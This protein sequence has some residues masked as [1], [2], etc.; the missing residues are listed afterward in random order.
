MDSENWID[1][2]VIHSWLNMARSQVCPDTLSKPLAQALTEAPLL[3]SHALASAL[4]VGSSYEGR[5]MGFNSL[6]TPLGMM[7]NMFDTCL[8]KGIRPCEISGSVEMINGL[9]AYLNALD[10][11]PSWTVFRTASGYIGRGPPLVKKG[12]KVC[13]F[14]GARTPFIIRKAAMPRF[15]P[16]T[17]YH[18]VGECYVEGLMSKEATRISRWKWGFI[19]LW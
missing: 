15:A 18:L 13:V 14:E 9:D 16:A 10:R 4:I 11:L 1:R 17:F 12:D 8:E 3:E 6:R 7:Y 2:K 19:T 5:P